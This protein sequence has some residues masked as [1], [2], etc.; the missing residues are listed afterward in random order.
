M[1]CQCGDIYHQAGYTVIQVPVQEAA[2]IPS[3]FVTK[4]EPAA[5]QELAGPTKFKTKPAATQEPTGP[6]N[7]KTKPAAT[8]EPVE[9]SSV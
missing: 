7:I 1:C 4:E 8:Q 6:S 2:P 5:T 3:P 9:P